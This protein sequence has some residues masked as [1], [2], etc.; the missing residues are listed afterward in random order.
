MKLPVSIVR[1][2]S[3]SSKA[4][5]QKT[6]R[7]IAVTADDWMGQV[8]QG[9]ASAAPLKTK[10]FVHRAY[11]AT[12]GYGVDLWHEGGDTVAYY[13][14]QAEALLPY[15]NLTENEREDLVLNT[16]KEQAAHS[17]VLV[18]AH[19][20]VPVVSDN[21]QPASSSLTCDGAFAVRYLRP[22]TV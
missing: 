12:L 2:F 5:L 1:I 9:Y 11:D 7:H 4:A 10:P 21:T 15:L 22:H 14:G 13:Y 17:Q 19:H 20:V 8:A 3:M 16:R 6:A 18:M